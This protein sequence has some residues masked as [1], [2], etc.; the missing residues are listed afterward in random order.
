M[1]YEEKNGRENAVLV[2]YA[3]RHST[4]FGRRGGSLAAC[5]APAE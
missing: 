4:E 2:P 3:E 5:K 1:C